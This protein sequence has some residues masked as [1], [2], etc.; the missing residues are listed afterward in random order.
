MLG[1]V[2]GIFGFRGEV[3]LFLDNPE[4]TWLHETREVVLVSPEGER[5][6]ARLKARPGAGRRILG[7]LDGVEDDVGAR[8]LMGWHVLARRQDLPDTGEHEWYT[9]DLLGLEVS[10]ENGEIVGT[11]RE[12]YQSG[13]VDV[14]EIQGPHG[15][16]YLP[17]LEQNLVEVTP[18]GITVNPEGLVWD[19][20]D[21]RP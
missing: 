5:R 6:T 12:I 2:T 21:G 10:T 8:A 19:D 9:A 11:L 3:R 20:P 14:W 18:V 15:T 7:A 4:S 13:P 16:C 1:R 17:V